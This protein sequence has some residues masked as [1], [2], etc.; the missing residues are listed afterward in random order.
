MTR[1]SDTL[2]CRLDE[3]SIRLGGCSGSGDM[4]SDTP[5]EATPAYEC[6]LSRNTCS[7]AGYDP[8]QNYMDYTEDNCL[9]RFTTKQRDRML[10][11]WN[12]YRAGK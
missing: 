1:A 3:S 10:V 4:V 5:A 8:V 12:V 2:V 7:S 6:D 9:S 11:Q